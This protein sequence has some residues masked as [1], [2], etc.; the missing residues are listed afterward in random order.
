[1]TMNSLNLMIVEIVICLA[2]AA[3]LGLLVGWLIRRTIAN[4]HAA[5]A[6]AAANARYKLLEESSQQDVKNLEDQIQNLASDLKSVHSNNQNLSTSLKDTESSIDMARTQSVELNKAQL[7]TNERLQA[8]IREKDLEINRLINA[9]SSTNSNLAAAAASMGA[10]SALVNQVSKYTGDDDEA[11]ETLDATTVLQNPIHE[12][13][14]DEITDEHTAK[15][16]S[17]LNASTDQLKGERQALL[18]ALSEG[19]ETIAIDHRD[20]PIDL[21]QSISNT[22]IDETIALND[23]DKTLKSEPDDFDDTEMSDTLETP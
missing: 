3:L 17:A 1:M 6:E 15:T 12:M 5:K 9:K 8:I 13:P 14:V 2:L 19:E 16:V 4:R 22:D 20:L 10:S 11:N 21:R 23:M 7:E 18:D